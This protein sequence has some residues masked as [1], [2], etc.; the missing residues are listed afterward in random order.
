MKKGYFCREKGVLHW[1]KDQRLIDPGV[2]NQSRTST[3]TNLGQG[4]QVSKTK[5]V[6]PLDM[7]RLLKYYV[8]DEHFFFNL[9]KFDFLFSIRDS[10]C[11]SVFLSTTIF[12]V[13]LVFFYALR[14]LLILITHIKQQTTLFKKRYIFLIQKDE[15]L[16]PLK[17]FLK[18]DI[19]FILFM[20]CYPLNSLEQ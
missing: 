1:F 3:D 13:L 19:F 7:L 5:F 14:F 20:F 11:L 12:F 2:L 16:F 4:Y 18:L 15:I 8:L 17:I 6:Q 10:V 9:G